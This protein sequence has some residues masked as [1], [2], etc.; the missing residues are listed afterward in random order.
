MVYKYF[1]AMVP[2]RMAILIPIGKSFN[3][4][5]A[6]FML[7]DFHI[8][9]TC[10]T[11][12]HDTMKDMAL[13]SYERGIKLLCFTDHV[14]LD[15]YRTGKPDY[16]CFDVWDEIVR[17]HAEAVAAAPE[18][19]EILTGI[20]LGQANHDPER[21]ERI[22]STKGLDFVIG[23]LHN[24]R[25]TPDFSI[26]RYIS[27]ADCKYYLSR[28]V[29]ELIEL[30]LLNCYDVMAHIGYTRRYM[31][32]DGFD[33]PLTMKNHGE[34]LDELFRN[35]IT[36]GKGIEVNCSGLRNAGIHNTIPSFS[37][38]KHYRELGGEIITVGSDAHCTGD[39]GVGIERGF[40]LLR[41]AGFEY[42]TVF[43]QRKPE[44]IKL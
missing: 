17:Q 22:A 14:D 30:S 33:M 43:R 28:Y 8:H 35:L 31:L 5:G 38:I 39:A 12:A 27:V 24:L 29:D 25:D 32:R 41:E 6:F 37:V 20:E 26:M 9:S 19:L 2:R 21:A 23:S 34:G 4:L 16:K 1:L 7:T 13:A 11:D 18:D 40:E 44:F 10:S 36:S 3:E 42:F 15:D